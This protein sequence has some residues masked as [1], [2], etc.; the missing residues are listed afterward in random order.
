M[1]QIIT[2]A[3]ECM[4]EFS[5]TES[6]L[7]RR[8]FAGDT[9][10]TAWYLRRLLP[11]DVAVDYVTRIGD[12]RQSQDMLAFMRESCV[13]TRHVKVMAGKSCGLYT[14]A[15]EAGERSFCYWRSASAARHLADDPALLQEALGASDCL[16]FSGITLAILPP[17]GREALLAVAKARK[18]AGAMVAFDPNIRPRLWSGPDEIRDW[19]NRAYA[20]ASL[21]L[22]SFADEAAIFG[23]AKPEATATRLAALGVGEIVVK[24]GGEPSQVVS[25]AGASF[26]PAPAAITPRD[27]TGAGDSFNAGYIAR[28]VQ[29]GTPEQAAA[30]AHDLAGQVIQ[31][32]GALVP[33]AIPHAPH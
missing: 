18:E 10:N 31:G 27:T 11:Q 4:V 14:I 29:G 21:A 26:V 12:D 5:S 16:V 28:R 6:G 25:A 22:P 23:D 8:S 24:D 1:A 7:Y 17:V 3:G 19:L 15:L 32:Y 9:F 2:C 30:A 20:V 33:V 13:G